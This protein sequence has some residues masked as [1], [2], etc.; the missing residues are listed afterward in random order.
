MPTVYAHAIAA[1]SQAQECRLRRAV[2]N[3]TTTAAQISDSG[4]KFIASAPERDNSPCQISLAATANRCLTTTTIFLTL[5]RLTL[6]LTTLY[7]QNA[8]HAER[9]AT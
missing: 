7:H 8:T 3:Y 1:E 6:L 2:G 9:W 5:R 4:R